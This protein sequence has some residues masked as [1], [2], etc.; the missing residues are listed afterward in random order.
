MAGRIKGL[1]GIVFDL[2][3]TLIDT[4]QAHEISWVKAFEVN[5]F[6]VKIE[7]VEPLI[8]L[9]GKRIA[10]DLL[11]ENGLRLLPSIVNNK[12]S[13]Y[14]KLI[15]H[16]RLFPGTIDTLFEL[17]RSGFKLALAT[18]TVSDVLS[19][20]LQ[21]FQLE[22]LFDSIVAGSEIVKGKPD[23]EIF[24]KAFEKIGLEPNLGMIVGDTEYDILPALSI[25]ATSV[26]VLHGRKPKLS[27]MSDFMINE[28]PDLPKIFKDSMSRYSHTSPDNTRRFR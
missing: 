4:V 27:F 19:K 13:S 7:D 20:V 17:R 21:V 16:L 23:P 6:S 9:P 10:E 14:L 8:G 12:N 25:G 24:L 15:E 5:G 2:D 11:G 3:G 18:S 22:A 1:K 26:I 28:L